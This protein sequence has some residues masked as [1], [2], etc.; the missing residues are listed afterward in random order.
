M[1]KKELKKYLLKKYGIVY[2]RYYTACDDNAERYYEGQYELIED[3]FTDLFG[4]GF[5]LYIYYNL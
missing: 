1:T 4:K 5:R 3:M 2:E